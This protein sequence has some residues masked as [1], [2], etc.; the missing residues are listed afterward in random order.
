M[1]GLQVPRGLD[2]LCRHLN[3]FPEGEVDV[4]PIPFRRAEKKDFSIG[5][6][7]MKLLDHPNEGGIRGPVC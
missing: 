4:D 6:D 1:R 7:E 3:P 2:L 5:F